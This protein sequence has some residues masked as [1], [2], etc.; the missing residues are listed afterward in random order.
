MSHS[1][2]YQM[3][4]TPSEVYELNIR[5]GVIPQ[6]DHAQCMVEL[7]DPTTGVQIA[8]W[9]SPHGRWDS[10]PHMLDTALAK[11]HAQLGQALEP[12]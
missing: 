3:Q 8:M 4:L 2:W 11:A 9:S 5:V 6:T 12:F 1:D 10:W 7:K